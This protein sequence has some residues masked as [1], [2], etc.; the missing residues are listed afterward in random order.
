MIEYVLLFAAKLLLYFMVCK[1][2]PS[3]LA[4]EPNDHFAFASAWAGLRLILG[5]LATYP[6][7]L[8]LGQTDRLGLRPEVMYVLVLLVVRCALWW[9]VATLIL[10]R[11]KPNGKARVRDWLILGVSSSFAVDFLAWV[12]RANFKFFC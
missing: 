10:E 2:A 12:S 3:L 6:I 5:L 11:H 1:K 9:V 4:V 8:L 7:V